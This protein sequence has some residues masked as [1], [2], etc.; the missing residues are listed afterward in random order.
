ML[1]CYFVQMHVIYIYIY[2]G[3][4]NNN[5]NLDLRCVKFICEYLRQGYEQNGAHVCASRYYLCVFT[6][7]NP[8]MP[9]RGRE[10]GNFIAFDQI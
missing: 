8:Y 5:N 10:N 9:E 3:D 2:Y 1:F 7:S 4:N 6:A